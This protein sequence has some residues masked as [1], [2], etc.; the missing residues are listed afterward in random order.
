VNTRDFAAPELPVAKHNDI[1]LMPSDW[2]LIGQGSLRAVMTALERALRPDHITSM[3]QRVYQPAVAL[4]FYR[5]D[6]IVQVLSGEALIT[7]ELHITDKD[8]AFALGGKPERAEAFAAQPA[9]EL[10]I[11]YDADDLLVLH[12]DHNF[13]DERIVPVLKAIL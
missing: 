12:F 6:K 3:R 10:G 11:P 9:A 7:I 1:S 5:G 4:S 2:L 13:V 8:V